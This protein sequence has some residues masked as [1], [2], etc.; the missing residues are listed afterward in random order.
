M[1]GIMERILCDWNELNNMEEIEIIKEYADIGKFITLVTTCKQYFG[2][3]CTLY[4][5]TS[6][7]TLIVQLQCSFMHLFLASFWY[8][9]YQ[10]FF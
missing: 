8:C 9:F 1:Q 7:Q 4:S 5:I 2:F 6:I 3:F 10:I